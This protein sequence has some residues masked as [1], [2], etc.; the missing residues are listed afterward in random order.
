[1]PNGS[2]GMHLQSENR[3][4]LLVTVGFEGGASFRLAT[5]FLTIPR[6]ALKKVAYLHFIRKES[7][8]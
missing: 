6:G 1:M 8:H 2:R 7:C 4:G 5:V 3:P